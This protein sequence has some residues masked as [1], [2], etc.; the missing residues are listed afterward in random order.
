LPLA[1]F[2]K[3][4]ANHVTQAPKLPL[5]RFQQQHAN[6]VMQAPAPSQLAMMMAAGVDARG[7]DGGNAGAQDGGG[8]APHAPAPAP[9]TTTGRDGAPSTG[10]AAGPSNA[11]PPR[12][13][14]PK[15]R[16]GTPAAEAERLARNAKQ[17]ERRDNMS[18]AD[19]AKQ[20]RTLPRY[21]YKFWVGRDESRWLGDPGPG[22]RDGRP[23]SGCY[24]NPYPLFPLHF[25][26]SRCCG[27]DGE[28][29]PP[30]DSC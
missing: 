27:P 19:K 11:T 17:K 3:Q 12:P 16:V 24:S 5:A 10:G 7:G 8:A 23:S 6:H 2:Q 4:H 13:R 9:S 28:H 15:A 26:E 14:P 20:V 25:S 29:A 22:R 1:R 30:S 21:K 18:P